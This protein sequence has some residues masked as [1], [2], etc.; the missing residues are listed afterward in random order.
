[1]K[2]NHDLLPFEQLMSESIPEL[3]LYMDQVIQLFMSQ[4]ADQA[5]KEKVLTK[6]MVN[7]YAKAKLFPPTKNKKYNKTQIMMMN[8]IFQ[9]KGTL[10]LTDIK[11]ALQPLN[12]RMVVEADIE[13][14]FFAFYD[15][16]M[17]L[18]R[19]QHQNALEYIEQ[20]LK[21]ANEQLGN[22]NAY[23]TQLA[24]I[25]LLT[26]ISNMSRNLAEQLIITI[27]QHFETE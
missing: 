12:S 8:L 27:P 1:M 6:T 21:Q 4:Y 23:E 7:N 20:Q 26:Q 16:V 15:Q 22:V 5:D 13:A 25:I 11:T 17:E 19:V 2:L 10:S 18:T 24:Q 14:H 9:L 3:D